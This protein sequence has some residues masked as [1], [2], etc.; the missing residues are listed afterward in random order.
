MLELSTHLKKINIEKYFFISLMGSVHYL[1]PQYV[2]GQ[3]TLYSKQKHTIY[4][5]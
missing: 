2:A 5:N 1:M 4:S 3:T